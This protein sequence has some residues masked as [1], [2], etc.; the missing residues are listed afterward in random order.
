MADNIFKRVETDKKLP[1]EAKEEL[2]SNI[3]SAKLFLNITELF[4]TKYISTLSDLFKK[5]SR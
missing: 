2:V 5:I 1:K 3:E 4:G